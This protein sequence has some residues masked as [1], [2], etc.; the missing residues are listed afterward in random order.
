MSPFKLIGYFSS[1]LVLL[2]LVEFSGL[3]HQQMLASDRHTLDTDRARQ[4]LERGIELYERESFVSARDLWQES[5]LLY[6]RQEEVLGEALALNNLALAQQHL[7]AW[8]QSRKAIAKSL[9]LLQDRDNLGQQPGYWDILAK[10]SIT[11]GNWQW[12][13]GK[14]E[15]A[16]SSWQD[17]AQYYR[18]A[19]DRSGIIKAQINQAKAL[20]ALG[21]T[22]KAVKLLTTVEQLAVESDSELQAVG[23]RYLGI[24]YRNLGELERSEDLLQQSI[25]IGGTEENNLAWLELGN[26]Y[27]KQGERASIIGKDVVAAEYFTKSMQAYQQA[28]TSKTLLQARLNQLSLSVERGEYDR[29]ETLKAKIVFPDDLSANRANVYTLLNYANSLTC[30]YFPGNT[31]ADCNWRSRS[32]TVSYF[33][34]TNDRE[35][36]AIATTE[37]K[38]IIHRA[39]ALSFSS[40]DILAQAQAQAQLAVVYELEGNFTQAKQLNQQTLLLLEGKP[41]AELTYR[42]QWQLGRIFKQQGK[43]GEATI[44]YNQAIASLERVRENILFIDRQVQ[45]S[46][47]DRVEPVYREYIDLLLTTLDNTTPSPQNLRQAI[48]IIDALQVAELENFLD[49]DLSQLFR[50]DETSID[51]LSAK[52]YPLILSDRLVTIIDLPEQPLAYREIALDRERVTTT[53]NTLQE[54][55][56]QPGKTPEVLQQAEQIYQWLIEP[57]ELLLANNSQIE[58]LVFVPDGLLRNIPFGILYDGEEYLIEKGYALAISPQLQLFVPKP[59]KEPL[60]VLAGGVAIPQTIE[61]IEFPAIAEVQQEL[62]QIGT[63]IETNDPLLNEAFTEANIQEQIQQ[64]NF[65]AIHWKTH[66]VF[67]S[68]PAET[69]LVAYR[70]SIKAN[71]LQSLVQTASR[72]GQK[73]LEL[74]VLSACETARGDNR[75]IL[76]LAGLTVRTGARSA[77]STLWRADDRATTLLMTEFYQQ[78]TQPG[79]T[80]AEALQ[81]AQLSLLKQEGYF[82]PHYWGTYILVGNWL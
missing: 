76:G 12:Q 58:T 18:R 27:R 43:I 21:L 80:K 79:M 70:D 29:A 34:S 62:Q 50:L 35:E 65:S 52:I 28:A 82:A 69:F 2:L 63:E 39:I 36:T 72:D 66:G 48:K 45:F 37:L 15:L 64:N 24:G 75:A 81:K 23:L 6:A 68:D 73:P 67:S 33:D 42:L 3:N 60:N 74:L 41:A 8:E 25:T 13:T 5:A 49:C 11:Q 47:R 54:N 30:W 10:A 59:S 31:V 1:V 4:F 46:F 78:L 56:G 77:L 16:L 44:A 22:L 61:G 9:Q 19:E 32:T 55:L 14:L 40:Q 57:L 26:T 38:E 20:Q 7:G 71:E 51:P 17:A 53:L